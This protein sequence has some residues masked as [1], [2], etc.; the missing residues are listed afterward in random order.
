MRE[1]FPTRRTLLAGSAAAL[2]L[3]SARTLAQPMPDD[4]TVALWPGAMPGDRNTQIIRKVAEQSHDPARHDRFISGIARPVMIVKRPAKPNGSAVLIVPGGG[5][6]FLSYDN[7]GVSQAAWLN[8]RG[9]TAF[10][11]LHRLPG[12]G[13]DARELVPLQDAQRAMRL[14]RGGAARYAIDPARVAVLG[15]S[16]GGHLAGSLATRHAENTY[17]PVDLNDAQSARPDLAGMLYPVVSMEA[18]FTHGGSRDTLLGKGASVALRHAAS[19]EARVT[20]DT[21]PTFIVHAGDDGLVPVAN[22]L[23]FYTALNAAKVSAELHIFDEGGHGF[24]ARLP[25]TMTASAWPALFYAYGVR[26]AVFS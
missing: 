7:E 1:V 24:G 19:V 12:E 9:V 22:S 13:W 14:I 4:K 18:P 5:Y 21:P 17:H 26:K 25:K 2:T 20:K 10:I 23:A 6:A 15:F 16:A 11:L 3:A 8:A